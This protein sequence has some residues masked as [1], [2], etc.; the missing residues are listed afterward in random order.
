MA[1]SL[2]STSATTAHKTLKNL[3]QKGMGA[4]KKRPK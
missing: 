2:V 4:S 3:T 1:S